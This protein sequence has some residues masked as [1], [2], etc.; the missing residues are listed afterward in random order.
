MAGLAEVAKNV[1][2][3]VLLD[4]GMWRVKSGKITY[5]HEMETSHIQACLGMIRHHPKLWRQQFI[6]LLEAELTKRGIKPYGQD[7]G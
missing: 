4:M 1:L 2:D 6:P 3:N 5:I 7:E